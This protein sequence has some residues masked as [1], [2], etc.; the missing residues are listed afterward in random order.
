MSPLGH[1]WK[2]RSVACVHCRLR[3]CRNAR[4]GL[5]QRSAQDRSGGFI[6]APGEAFAQ[7]EEECDFPL[8]GISEKDEA[9]TSFGVGRRRLCRIGAEHALHR[10]RLTGPLR[11]QTR[12]PSMALDHIRS[13]SCR[14]AEG[15]YILHPRKDDATVVLF[16][17]VFSW[18]IEHVLSWKPPVDGGGMPLWFQK[19]T[20]ACFS[21]SCNH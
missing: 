5:Q 4:G 18:L 19:R 11:G 10:H 21:Q 3:R 17:L 6:Y 15:H 20:R 8:H 9:R 2:C 1:H 12:S 13:S 14:S 7:I 16:A